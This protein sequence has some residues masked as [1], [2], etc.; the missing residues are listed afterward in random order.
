MPDAIREAR[1]PSAESNGDAPGRGRLAGRHILVVGGGQ[2]VLDPTNDPIG[3]GRAISVL[4]AREGA[5]VAVAD[6]DRKSADDTVARIAQDGGRSF[7]I[8][9]DVSQEAAVMRM[10]EEAHSGLGGL[11]GM[12]LNVGIAIGGL[13]LARIGVAEWDRTLAVNLRGPTLCCR[14]GSIGSIPARPSS[15]SR[16]SPLCGPD[17]SSPPTTPPRPQISRIDA[18]TSPRGC[19]GRHPRQ[20]ALSGPGH[21]RSAAARVPSGNH[22]TPPEYR[23]GAWPPVGKSPMRRCF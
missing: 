17:H 6:L 13:G 3:N 12:V 1:A 15:S 7:S 9:A 21:R 11:D 4:C 5:A 23:L 22:A 8:E 18:P 16:R 20:H 2:Q 10:I 14:T 19:A